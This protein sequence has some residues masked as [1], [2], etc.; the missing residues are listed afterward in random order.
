MIL[1]GNGASFGSPQ[2]VSLN[3]SPADVAVLDLNSDGRPDLVASLPDRDQ[4]GIFYSRG[5]GQYA[6]VQLVN[7]GDQP[8]TLTVSD[9]DDDGKPDILATNRGDDTISILYNRFDPNE[10]YSYDADA[11]DPDGDTLTYRVVDGPGGLFVNAESGQVFWAA[12][13]DQIGQHRVVLEASDNR[14]GLATQS[15]QID[16]QASQE[17]APPLI[18]TTPTTTI[19]AGQ[20]FRY[21][22]SAFDRDRETLRYRLLHGPEGAKIDATTGLVEW[23][24]SNDRAIQLNPYASSGYVE[25]PNSSTLKPTSITVEGWYKFHSTTLAAVAKYCSRWTGPEVL[26]PICYTPPLLANWY[27]ILIKRQRR[28]SSDSKETS[29]RPSGSGTTLLFSFDDD[30]GLLNIFVDGELLASRS[31]DKSILL[32]SRQSLSGYR[33]FIVA[34]RNDR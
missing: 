24:G 34:A 29:F 2:Y 18:A 14:G 21:Q 15:F 31:T 25:V 3:S 28:N 17:N 23:D 16:V 10:I 4:L 12:S 30:S 32:R 5:G 1:P 19:G 33:G 20:S 8:S 9:L 27:W 13:P 22:A 7:I 26:L 6:S 11:L